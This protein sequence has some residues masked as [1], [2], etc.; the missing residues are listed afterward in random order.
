MYIRIA[1]QIELK[2]QAFFNIEITN[3]LYKVYELILFSFVE[4]LDEK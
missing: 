2:K 1:I 3:R 4:W